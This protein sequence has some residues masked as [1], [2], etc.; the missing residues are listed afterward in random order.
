MAPKNITI[1]S[2]FYNQTHHGNWIVTFGLSLYS[3][4]VVVVVVSRVSTP[5]QTQI[6][7]G[8][9]VYPFTTPDCCTA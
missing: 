6:G 7:L 9:R 5:G 1:Q 2:P 3:I 8:P 4:F